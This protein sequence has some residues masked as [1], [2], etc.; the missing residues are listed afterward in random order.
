MSMTPDQ[1]IAFCGDT[2]QEFYN[3]CFLNNRPFAPCN[4][5][6]MVYTA[7]GVLRA[8]YLGSITP[9]EGA[10]GHYHPKVVNQALISWAFHQ[11][12]ADRDK[13]EVVVVEAYPFS[14]LTVENFTHY[15]NGEIDVLSLSLG[16]RVKGVD[17]IK[18]MRPVR[19]DHAVMAAQAVKIRRVQ[20]DG[21]QHRYARAAFITEYAEEFSPNPF[22][23]CSLA[24]GL[25]NL[26]ESHGRQFDYKADSEQVVYG[27]ANQITV[28][29]DLE[30]DGVKINVLGST[31]VYKYERH[32]HESA[33]NCVNGLIEALQ[34]R[35][36]I[37]FSAPA[38]S[39]IVQFQEHLCD[40]LPKYVG[41]FTNGLH[42]LVL[43]RKKTL[44]NRKEILGTLFTCVD[45]RGN[46]YLLWVVEEEGK[47]KARRE[48][49]EVRDREMFMSQ[50]INDM[51]V[52]TEE[53]E[54]NHE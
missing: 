25:E 2:L 5:H 4:L 39:W 6:I 47:M 28:V 11:G 14:G 24:Y 52:K 44:S 23:A 29:H 17:G 15:L 36:P 38:K 35:E 43:H 33:L 19:R 22:E 50:I 53:K 37:E 3:I 54:E 48:L 13:A 8:E 16:V 20:A 12:Y 10:L 51:K 31:T 26:A 46:L 27:I 21:V 18:A 49:F 45:G 7:M 30:T 9:H 32:Q 1:H 40:M 41:Q 34:P 42:E